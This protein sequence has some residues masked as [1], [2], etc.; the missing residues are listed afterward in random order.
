MMTQ[1]PTPDIPSSLSPIPRRIVSV[2]AGLLLLNAIALVDLAHRLGAL[3]TSIKWQTAIGASFLTGIALL[4]FLAR[5]RG[6]RSA[7]LS[8][9]ALRLRSFGASLGPAGGVAFVLLLPVLPIVTAQ[10]AVKAFEPLSMRIVLWWLLALM[11]AVALLGLR[12]GYRFLSLVAFS[13]VA[14]A[15]A[16]QLSGYLP[17]ISTYPL[18]LGWSE[19]SR[20]YNAS[21][22]FAERIY[23]QPAPLPV[24]HPSRYL[25]Q[26]VP[27]I[28]GDLPLWAHRAWQVLLW[29]GVTLGT[30]I[31]LARRARL[32]NRLARATLIGVGYLFLMQG[33]VYY[34]L[35]P[36]AAIVLVGASK[37][38]P[39]RTLLAVLLA[40]A[41]AGISRVNWYPVPALVAISLYVLEQP[42]T[43]TRRRV[44]AYL[45]WP[46]VYAIGGVL[47]A[48]AASRAYAAVSGNPAAEFASSFTS[49]LLWY[50]LF[51]SPTYPPGVL[52]AI[53]LASAIPL[54]LIVLWARHHRRELHPIRWTV[55]AGALAVLFAGGLIV[56]AK[57]GGGGNL[58]NLDAYLVLL[59]FLGVQL[60]LGQVT[61]EA[62]DASAMWRPSMW[63]L[64]AGL[65]VPV[66]FALASSP[67]F[68]PLD[69]ENARS[70]VRR[71][72]QAV[73][74]ARNDGQEV[75]FISERHL[76]AFEHLEVALEPDYE[77]VY[78][79]EMAMAGNATYLEAFEA[80]LAAHRF[81][82]IVTE[83]LNTRLRGSEYTFGEEN[84]VWARRV[85][86][87]LLRHY[88]MAV[89]QGGIWLMVPR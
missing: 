31:V 28:F 29:I 86:A 62:G 3:W 15:V 48:F 82:L 4:L 54:L 56:S 69:F 61:S 18:S 66:A 60:I 24:L 32:E 34:H 26:S 25:M 14:L 80:D 44:L 41:W 63:V 59:L 68:Q 65:L 35:L 16:Y 85:A 47:S 13:G 1:G 67:A 9:L 53:L 87:P 21:L 71:V 74:Q 75:L 72:S 10:L 50:R 6:T 89:E 77:K 8:V 49:D 17:A 39:W 55:L 11:G 57:I 33:P 42:L 5:T 46:T 36:C 70:T 83:R 79:M 40:S 2:T 52:P 43:S 45:R 22:F 73:S 30:S 23:A 51:P 7:R 88:R 20:Y 84:D 64:G 37:D 81:G 78:L 58:H 76:I 38:R 12:K 19:T 27:F